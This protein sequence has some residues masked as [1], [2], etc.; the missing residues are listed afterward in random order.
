MAPVHL[1]DLFNAI[2]ETKGRLWDNV[3]GTF[4]TQS[5][6]NGENAC[7]AERIGQVNSSPGSYSAA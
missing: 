6:Q 5:V 3:A 1:F 7:Q 4:P 2:V